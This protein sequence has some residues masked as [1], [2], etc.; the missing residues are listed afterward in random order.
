MTTP[1][2]QMHSASFDPIDLLNQTLNVNLI[3]PFVTDEDAARKSTP[4]PHGG[5]V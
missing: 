3:N 1:V 4:L 5:G 2:N